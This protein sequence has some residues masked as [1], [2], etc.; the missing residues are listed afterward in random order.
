MIH[1]APS[2]TKTAVAAEASAR[3]AMI[4]VLSPRLMRERALFVV[5][6][7]QHG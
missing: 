2:R 6:S 1:I 7:I 4:R 3:A 5:L